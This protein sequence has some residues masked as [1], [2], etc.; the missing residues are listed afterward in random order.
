MCPCEKCFPD[1]LLHCV[2][3]PAA[4]FSFLFVI[5]LRQKRNGISRS[6]LK[7]NWKL[8]SAR[9]S[10][11]SKSQAA[12]FSFLIIYQQHSELCGNIYSTTFQSASYMNTGSY[13]KAPTVDFS[14]CKL[15]V[16]Q[17]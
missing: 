2:S 17:A 7:G 12:Y 15:F 13:L 5:L 8:V 6:D 14:C 3:V 16:M 9:K 11:I 1:L 4:N 10:L